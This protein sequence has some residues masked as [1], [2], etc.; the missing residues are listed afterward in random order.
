ML[1]GGVK[2]YD[3]GHVMLILGVRWSVQGV[4]G[5][6]EAP[7]GEISLGHIF[8]EFSPRWGSGC[9]YSNR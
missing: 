9:W 7:E 6:G 2:E 5:E 1:V 3:L 4:A 8:A